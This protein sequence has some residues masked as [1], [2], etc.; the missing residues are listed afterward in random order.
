MSLGCYLVHKVSQWLV[1]TEF[2][3][4]KW[5]PLY[6]LLGHYNATINFILII[7][8]IFVGKGDERKHMRAKNEKGVIFII[9]ASIDNEKTKFSYDWLLNPL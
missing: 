5:L 8:I 7:I 4:C 9:I 3:F 2:C 1:F 6:I